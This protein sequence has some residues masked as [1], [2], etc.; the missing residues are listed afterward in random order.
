MTR[1]KTFDLVR[2][3]GTSK[4]GGFGFLVNYNDCK[5][6]VLTKENSNGSMVPD[7]VCECIVYYVENYTLPKPLREKEEQGES[8]DSARNERINQNGELKA[9]H[10][11]D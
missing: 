9:G 6:C 7:G 5:S 4:S 3:E 2:E 10:A 11:Y 1:S 8:D